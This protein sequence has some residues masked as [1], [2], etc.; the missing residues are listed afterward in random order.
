MDQEAASAPRM[1]SEEGRLSPTIPSTAATEGN[2]EAKDD[3]DGCE[4]IVATFDALV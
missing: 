3:I 4:I 2:E 1:P